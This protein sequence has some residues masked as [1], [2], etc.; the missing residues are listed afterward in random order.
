M[1]PIL[2]N[3]LITVASGFTVSVIATTS[4]TIIAAKEQ[5]VMIKHLEDRLNRCD[6]R[7]ERESN[8]IDRMQELLYKGGN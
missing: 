6:A 7:C 4:A 8:K 3:I 5:A 2:K 1:N